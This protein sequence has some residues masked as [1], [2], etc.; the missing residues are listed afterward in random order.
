L[1]EFNKSGVHSEVSTKERKVGHRKLS[2]RVKNIF[3][4]NE[5]SANKAHT[6]KGDDMR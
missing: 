6:V 5:V 1:W 3:T 4:E 2:R